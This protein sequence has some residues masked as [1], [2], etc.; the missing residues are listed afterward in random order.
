M[1]FCGFPYAIF[2]VV[3]FFQ[4]FAPQT[5]DSVTS[6]TCP[7]CQ[8]VFVRVGNHLKGCPQRK[9]RDYDHLLSKKT[10]SK[11][12]KVRKEACPKCGKLYLRLET[13][14]RNSATCKN[15]T[16]LD[17]EQTNEAS[18]QE[19][20]PG[21]PTIVQ[22]ESANPHLPPSLSFKTL[23]HIKVPKTEEE[24]RTADDFFRLNLVPEVCASHSVDEMNDIL[25]KGIYE[26][27][28]KS[29]NPG[30]HHLGQSHQHN[31]HPGQ[32]HQH[33]Q[34]PHN[35][36]LKKVREEKKAIK[37]QL[38]SLRKSGNEKECQ[39]LAQEFHNLLRR[40]SK[41]IKEENK[42]EIK[43]KTQYERKECHCN[44]RRI[45][46]RLL[47]DDEK[48]TSIQPQFTKSQADKYF[49]ETYKSE[50]ASFRRPNLMKIV[51]EP[52]VPFDM[53]P[54]CS[55]EVIFIL[56]RCKPS[57][58]PSPTDQIPYSVLRNCP[59][60]LPALV[61]L[62]N[63]CWESHKVPQQWKVGVLRLL[64]KK[65]AE[66]DPK[67]PT[68]FRPIA[69]TSCIGK[70]YTSIIK[71]R[72]L[73]FMTINGYLDTTVQKAFIDGIPGCTEHHIK[74]LSMIEDARKKHKSLSVC[75]L[76]IANAFGSVHHNLIQ[77]SL[78]HYH[79]PHHL[80]SVISDLY[81]NLAGVITS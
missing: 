67:D 17:S 4:F 5:R 58:S 35:R 63:S 49:K 22:T 26:H 55:E 14:L 13:H 48:Y 65:T 21:E 44:F 52:T 59:S 79:A 51:A 64:G 81:N 28:Y 3:R 75:W 40:Y 29:N 24:W 10:L 42:K 33:N 23:P 76:D 60:L 31:H 69:L 73:D 72:W 32:S 12:N 71:R 1:E 36:V 50:P 74:L 19:A 56:N 53:A 41:L 57:S 47:D 8:K 25:S 38:R 34:H 62:F 43:R 77:F 54:I 16:L 18:V 7:F 6:N 61:Q 2:E 68:N 66:S 46:S 78:K 30:N 37:K 80:V 9:G 20:D 15:P 11:R 70:V 27:L 39:V 45:V